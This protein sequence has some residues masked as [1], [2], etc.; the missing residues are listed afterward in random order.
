MK[1]FLLY[2]SFLPTILFGQGY[3][4]NNPVWEIGTGGL[5][6][7]CSF[8]CIQY[9]S[10][11][12]YLKGDTIINGHSYK[13][14]FSKSLIWYRWPGS[15]TPPPCC[16]GTITYN[17]TLHP[18]A[19]LRD[20][21]QSVFYQDTLGSPE[22]LLYNF[23]LSVGD[24]LPVTYN[25]YDSTI[26]IVAIDSIP[27]SNFY[28]KIFTLSNGANAHYLLE[29]IGSDYGLIE[30]LWLIIDWSSNLECYGI[31]DSMYYPSPGPIC[32]NGVG[33]Q[34][35]NSINDFGITIIPNPASHYI[36]LETTN[37]I[38]HFDSFVIQ[39]SINQ[40]LITKSI[41]RVAKFQVDVSDL[42]HGVYFVIAK[43]STGVS[44]YKT[45]V[46]N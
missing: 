19:F 7:S 3:F 13:Q 36:S 20:T 40:T 21:F 39:N 1:A 5:H 27:I 35:P 28:R 24:S 38:I 16:Q 17:D 30:P 41:N 34:E 32:T 29:G 10:I 9:N 31:N 11:N 37:P 46:K 8:S 25:N 6:G 18:I 14:L 26:T 12:Y 2:L 43:L 4:D 44:G 15:I 42:S 45:F 23:N 33:I 22:A